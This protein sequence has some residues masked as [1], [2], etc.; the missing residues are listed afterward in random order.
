MKSNDRNPNADSILAAH[1]SQPQPSPVQKLTP[2]FSLPARSSAAINASQCRINT[3]TPGADASTPVKLEAMDALTMRWLPLPTPLD[4]GLQRMAQPLAHCTGACHSPAAR[5]AGQGQLCGSLRP[6]IP[7]NAI[8]ARANLTRR[9]FCRLGACVLAIHC[10][11]GPIE[12]NW[13]DEVPRF[14]VRSLRGLKG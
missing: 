2:R 11:I 6:R 13:A 5:R 12:A 8:T 9:A 14:P 10:L 7:N 1:P 4:N 3:Q